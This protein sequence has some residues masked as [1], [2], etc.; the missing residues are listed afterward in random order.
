MVI[1]LACSCW[2]FVCTFFNLHLSFSVNLTSHRREYYPILGVLQGVV[3]LDALKDEVT[4]RLTNAR[5]KCL[6]DSRVLVPGC[7]KV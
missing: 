7:F 6:T 1:I 4:V 3:C 5:R 2:L